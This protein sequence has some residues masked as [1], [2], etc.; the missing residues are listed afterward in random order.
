MIMKS[1]ING[2]KYKYNWNVQSRGYNF[3]LKEIERLFE[4]YENS[5]E[6]TKEMLIDKDITSKKSTEM[7]IEVK[8]S[9]RILNIDKEKILKSIENK[10][11]DLLFL[12]RDKYKNKENK[13]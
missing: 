10:D 1:K 2:D 5:I 9:I 12:M 13:K 8:E 11:S 3:I 4:Y 7:I 6:T